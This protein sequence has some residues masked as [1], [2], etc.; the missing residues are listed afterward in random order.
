MVKAVINSYQ[1]FALLGQ[2]A[3]SI[4][5][6]LYLSKLLFKSKAFDK[7]RK[8]ISPHSYLLAFLL[9]FIA[10]LASL[11]LSEVAKFQPCILCWYQRTMMYPQPLLLYTAIVRNERFLKP[12]L[13]VLNVIGAG[14]AVY[15]YALQIAPKGVLLPC[16]KDLT[17][18]SVSCVKGYKF[19]MG[20]M[21]FPL[22]SLTVFS[23][24]IILL[25]MDVKNPKRSK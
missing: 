18:V 4:V 22:M 16:A 9:S 1:Y 11:F 12:Y 17:G 19:Y 25:L 7:L 6:L 20:Y 5:I 10:T 14:V 2:I 13:L 8:R 21:S 23:L 15:H 3:I 24:I